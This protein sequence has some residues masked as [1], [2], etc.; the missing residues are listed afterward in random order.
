MRP[1][2]ARARTI[3]LSIAL[4]T[5]GIGALATV[6]VAASAGTTWNIQV[7]SLESPSSLT[8]ANRFYPSEITIHP[9]DTVR[10]RWGGFHTVTFNPPAN[11]SLFDY[12][13]PGGY[14]PGPLTSPS[15][16]VSGV[17]FGPPGSPPPPFNV[18]FATTLPS[19]TYHFQC[20]LHQF[21]KGSVTVTNEP[22]H[23]TD[24]QNQQLAATEIKADSQRVAALDRHATGVTREDRGEAV[25]GI[26]TKVVE[27]VKFYP[28]AI[29]VH[30]GDRLTFTDLDVQEP[31]T[32]TFG[33]VAG[34]PRD[35][36]VGAFPSGPGNP[37]AYDGS[38]A[39]NSGFLLYPSM[40][41]YWRL[42]L[43][44]ISAL[45]PTTQFSVTFTRAT[46][47]GK[48]IQFYCFIHGFRNPDGSVGGMSGNITVLPAEGGGDRN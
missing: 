31:H 25:V 18:R 22:L 45:Q 39:L 37:Q 19:G 6:P 3:G 26:S 9:G 14:Q 34:N 23:R 10:F 21:M 20:M 30:V 4:A 7:G 46:A 29:T 33:P 12:F 5:A 13:G 27:V 44:P 35:P 38:S 16:W 40:Y 41:N 24:A 15:Q 1:L 28:Q 17:P 43:T 2:V 47:V 11:K 36:T 48:P 32:V 8:S 42:G